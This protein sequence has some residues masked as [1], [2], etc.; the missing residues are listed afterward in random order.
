MKDLIIK[1]VLQNAVRHDGKAN[2]GAIIGQILNEDP[3][4]KSKIKEISKDIQ[5]IVNEVNSLNIEEQKTKLLSIDPKLLE[6]R[7]VKRK[8]K[9]PKLNIK[10]LVMRFEPSPSGALHIGHAYVL[11][12]NHLICKKN[13]GKLILRIG[14]TNPANVI[15]KAYNLIEEDA[16]WLTDIDKVYIQSDRLDIYYKYAE[17]VLKQNNAYICTCNK[18]DF[19]SKLSKSMPCPCRELKNQPERWE[20]MKTKYKPGDAVLR[21]KTD[22]KHKN[23][24]MRDWPAFR[25]SEVPHPKTKTKYRIWPLMNFSVAVDDHEMK[26]TATVRAK[27]QRD[28]EKR[29]KYLCDYLGWKQPQNMYVGMIN[30][31]NLKLSSSYAQRLIKEKR[32]DGW[33]DIRLPF[34]P[35][36][37]RRGYQKE[38]LLKFAEEIGITETDKTTNKEDF[39]KSINSFNRDLI[40]KKA[41]RYFTI[42]EPY[43]KI[44]ITNAPEKNIQLDLYPKI[45]LG[46]R[47]FFTKGKFYFEEKFKKDQVYRLMHLYNIKN[48]EFVSEEMDERFSAKMIHWLPEKSVDIQILDEKNK[49]VKGLAEEAILKV[50]E[51]EIIQFE[52]HFFAKLINKEKMRFI[53]LHS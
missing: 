46:G 32:R 21:I 4:L 17:Q 30:F 15:T 27:D 37:R 3:K 23:P 45:R 33:D 49:L 31:S 18:E 39:F 14:D 35:S 26:I 1:Y 43:K 40:D 25:I 6:K 50:K 10:N 44:E 34:L 20:L 51:N 42:L 38:A 8:E 16:R 22:I 9:I 12:L 52:R 5:K 2:P 11:A 28:N 48:R 53:Y 36:L 19:K 47:K 41:D 29:Q 7:E 24:A 13:N